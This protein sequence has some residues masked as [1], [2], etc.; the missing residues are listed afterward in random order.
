MS[1]RQHSGANGEPPAASPAETREL[2]DE[3]AAAFGVTRS[4]SRRR[5]AARGDGEPLSET[6]EPARANTRPPAVA[7]TVAARSVSSDSAVRSP[8]TS[9]ALRVAMW[10]PSLSTLAV[11][12][13]TMSMHLWSSG[14]VSSRIIRSGR[15]TRSS[16]CSTRNFRKARPQPALR[17]TFS[18]PSLLNSD[19]APKGSANR[20]ARR[21][22]RHFC[23]S[24]LHVSSSPLCSTA[25]SCRLCS[26]RTTQTVSAVTVARSC[27]STPKK[28]SS[29]KTRGCSSTC[30]S[31]GSRPA[32]ST[33]KLPCTAKQ[34]Q[35]PG[36]IAS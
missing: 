7:T 25:W 1:T 30:A 16:R 12:S 11:P 22:S 19:S 2:V 9:P 10:Q 28:P 26:I 21:S 4:C 20:F 27:S 35:S 33:V 14:C 5:G 29:P 36:L 34:S 13:T 6:R 32:V 3:Y 24:L 23:A 31:R 8:K 18:R 17:N 15:K